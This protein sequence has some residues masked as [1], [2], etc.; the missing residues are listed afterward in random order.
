M[1]NM[2]LVGMAVQLALAIETQRASEFSKLK[3]RWPI[4]H[5]FMGIAG[6]TA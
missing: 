5:S 3:S 2:N 6:K 4:F 1:I